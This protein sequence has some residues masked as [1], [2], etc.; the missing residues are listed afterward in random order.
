LIRFERQVGSILASL[1]MSQDKA[2]TA[3]SFGLPTH[4]WMPLIQDDPQLLHG[5][6]NYPRLVI[7]GGGFPIEIGG[8]LVGGLGVSGGRYGEDMDVAQS[9]L[10]ILRSDPSQQ[11]AGSTCGRL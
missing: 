8:K 1:S 3:A 6:P 2:H 11:G 9:A 4:E 5:I 10:A 7:I